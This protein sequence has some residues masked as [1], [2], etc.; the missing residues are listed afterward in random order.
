[1]E[2]YV[3][4]PRSLKQMIMSALGKVW[5]VWHGRNEV[6]R[7]CKV[8]NK[9]RWWACEIC[10]RETERIEVDHIQPI[11]KPEDG[12]VDWNRYIE[13]KFVEADKLQGLCHECH[14]TKSKEEN[15]I[16]RESKKKRKQ[17]E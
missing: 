2:C 6:K 9:T 13:A 7:R 11:V 3:K 16:R 8:P 5:M 10:K 12:F 4:K 17:D 1:M 15:K 14:Q